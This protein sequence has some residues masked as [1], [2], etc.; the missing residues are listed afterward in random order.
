MK[1][2]NKYYIIAIISLVAWLIIASIGGPTFA[3]IN[4]V[5]N[6][7]EGSYLPK[8]AESTQVQNQISKFEQTNSF[9]AII[10]IQSK[11]SLTKTDLL[12][13]SNLSSQFKSVPGV[14]IS[15]NTFIVG[16]V[17]SKDKTAAEFVVPTSA[18]TDNNPTINALHLVLANNKPSNLTTYI[19]GPAGIINA[20]SNAFN[21]ING[22]L[23]IV[24]IVAV[25]VILLAVYRSLLLPILVLL[26]AVFALSGSILLVYY[27]AKNNIVQL[28]GESQGILSI[29]V[30]GATT[31]YSILFLS[32]F[33]EKLHQFES[34]F[35]AIRESIKSTWEPVTAAAMT[36][37]AGLFSLLFSELNSNR[38]LGP[39]AATGIIMSFFTAM[40][41]F[42]ALLLIF[43]RKSF[44]P[45]KVSYEPKQT[46]KNEGSKFNLYSNFW[47]KVASFVEKKYRLI[48]ISLSIILIAIILIGLPTFKASGV[49]QSQNI[50]GKSEAVTGQNLLSKYFPAGSGNPMQII[51][52]ATDAAAVINYLNNTTGISSAVVL[53]NINPVTKL[54]VPIVVNGKVLINAVINYQGQSPQAEN[55]VNSL[56]TSLKVY[57]KNVLVGGNSAIQLDTNNA[58]KHDLKTIIPIVLAIIFV[59]LIILLRSVL[60]PVILIISVIISYASTLAISAL[61][62]NHVFHFPGSDPSVPLFGFIFLVALGVDYNIFLMTRIREES[63]KSSTRY[64]ILKGLSVTGSV[65]TSAGV[66]L[67]ATFAALGVIPIL[68]LAE[69]AFIVSFGVLLDTLIIR[70]LL[71]PALS[72]DIGQLIWWPFTKRFKKD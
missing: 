69:I 64:G 34:K 36:V 30:I 17:L 5:S 67:S 8:S 3:K 33:K 38:G 11:T 16:P 51:T 39:V 14:Y 7:N 31:D 35:D 52:K 19:T 60:A 59:I 6:N 61:L 58:A 22:I 44:W 1:Q 9:P 13:L 48:W 70:S 21:G 27:L 56:R 54:N 29:L 62:F 25:L 50:I 37:I 71:V 23:T 57:D 43:G 47:N 24:A 2:K 20:F 55:L 10:F 63:L 68:F 26:S 72:Y 28:N 45:L 15:K 41:F 42:P 53:G 66:V 12:Y 18:T 40:T 46:A 49:S 4:S 65:I 32:R